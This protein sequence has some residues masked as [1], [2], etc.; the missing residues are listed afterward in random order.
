[1][2]IFFVLAAL[3][4]VTLLTNQLSAHFMQRCRSKLTF[5]LPFPGFALR[6]LA[7]SF[8]FPASK[9]RISILNGLPFFLAPFAL[10][11][12]ARRLFASE[13]ISMKWRDVLRALGV[14]PWASV[15][16]L[17]PKLS[18]V[19]RNNSLS[20]TVNWKSIHLMSDGTENLSNAPSCM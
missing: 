4:T 19:M 18:S 6:L 14:R 1:M 2:A 8:G 12:S 10:L 9:S 13:I 11:A 3:R 17:Y 20:T 5:F 16:N 15:E 7:F